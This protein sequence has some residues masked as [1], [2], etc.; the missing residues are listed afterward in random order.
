MSR[1]RSIINEPTGLSAATQS[2]RH[3]HYTA[4]AWHKYNVIITSMSYV[5]AG[6]ARNPSSGESFGGADTI[7]IYSTL[8]S[9]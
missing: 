5:P 2:F 3:E 7:L 4:D 6:Y 1:Q 9:L 8:V